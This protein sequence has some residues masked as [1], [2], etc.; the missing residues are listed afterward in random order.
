CRV[1]QSLAQYCVGANYAWAMAEGLF[2][3]RLLV[4]T[5]GRR[6]VPAFLLL[7][8]GVPVLFVVPWVVLRYLYENEGCWERN[9][10]VAVWW[11]I[12]CPILVAVA[13]NFVVFVRIVRI[14][15][16]KVRAH[17]VSRGDTRLRLARSTLTLIPLLG[18]H[19]VVFAL[20]G[21]GEGGGSLRLARLCLHLLLTSAQGLVVSV[22]YCFTNKEV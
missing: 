21:E 22:L 4:A 14:L 3:L 2:L 20:A 13:V 9:E 7:G 19:E 1:A 6:C 15:V 18:V 11:V 17:Q 5:S 8:W 10:K 12:R 16:A